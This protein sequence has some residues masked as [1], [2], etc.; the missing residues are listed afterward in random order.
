MRKLHIAGVCDAGLTGFY[1]IIALIIQSLSLSN[2]LT[3]VLLTKN[4]RG[5]IRED[6]RVTNAI[7]YKN[8]AIIKTATPNMNFDLS[9]SRVI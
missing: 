1:Y 7:F 4:K 9:S 3:V 5:E 6:A 8:T 2:L